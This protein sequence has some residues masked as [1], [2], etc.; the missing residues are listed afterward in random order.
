MWLLYCLALA[1]TFLPAIKIF[2]FEQQNKEEARCQWWS[3]SIMECFFQPNLTNEGF[4]E[5]Q[6]DPHNFHWLG[7]VWHYTN[8]VEK[9]KIKRYP[10]FGRATYTKKIGTATKSK[11][12]LH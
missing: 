3:S 1:R 5:R 10:K 11:I 2:L 8:F 12:I 9:I 6:G 7:G 4:K